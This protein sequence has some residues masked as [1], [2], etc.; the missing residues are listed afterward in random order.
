MAGF[1][2]N[3]R[4]DTIKGYIKYVSDYEVVKHAFF[5]KELHS[6]QTISL[7]PSWVKKIVFENGRLFEKLELQKEV[8]GINMSSYIFGKTLVKGL[9][10][11]YDISV[12]MNDIDIKF[13]VVKDC[14]NYV[15]VEENKF[16]EMSDGHIDEDKIVP[17][18]R[19]L[20]TLL[21]L[22]KECDTLKPLISNLKFSESSLINVIEKYNKCKGNDSS[23][24]VCSVPLNY[25]NK[26]NF[27][28]KNFLYVSPVIFFKNNT[29]SLIDNKSFGYSLSLYNPDVSYYFSF[30]VGLQYLY[31]KYNIHYIYQF[32]VK[33]VQVEN[34]YFSLPISFNYNFITRKNL[35][36]FTTLGGKISVPKNSLSYINAIKVE[37]SSVLP[38]IN[39]LSPNLYLLPLSGIFGFGFT[40]RHLFVQYN[41]QNRLMSQLSIGIEF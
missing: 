23:L 39:I 8:N 9:C 12:S 15:L 16:F 41:F 40:Y 34:R 25:K 7:S 37:N 30:N 18:R 33:D 26:S 31:L 24:Y 13:V 1:Y 28:I 11:L 38:D 3:D 10:S 6:K 27:K 14:K 17:D 5:K 29:F 19:Y 4:G 32:L 36:V 21:V 2:I 22:L 20:N 35:K